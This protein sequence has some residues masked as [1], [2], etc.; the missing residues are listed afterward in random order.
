M[1]FAAGGRIARG[2]H[3]LFEAS[4]LFKGLLA[5]SEAIAGIGLF[6]TSN[7]AILAYVTWLTKNEIAEDPTDRLALLAQKSVAALS[8]E[9]QHFYAFYLAS[10]GVLKLAMVLALA[11]R[12]SWAYPLAMLVLSG[13]VVYQLYSYVEGG[14][15]LLL[16]LSGLDVLMITL[17][18]REYLLMRHGHPT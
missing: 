10:H 3:Q 13:F 7:P 12:V 1:V 6:F 2:L 15:P 18:W 11:W 16:A 9:T 8:I 17:V 14:S 5:G 4:L